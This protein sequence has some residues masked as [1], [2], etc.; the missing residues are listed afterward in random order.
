M[1]IV[2][3]V[4]F[5]GTPDANDILAA[6]KLIREE[7]ARRAALTPPLAALPSGNAAQIKS[8]ALTIVLANLA[9]W[10]GSYTAQ[11]RN[12]VARLTDAQ[13]EELRAAVNTRLNA[14]D[15]FDTILADASS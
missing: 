1:N 12:E 14:G 7:N 2:F 10:W 4:D 13:L 9:Q 11:A 8:S 6:R 3:T 5:T 15:T